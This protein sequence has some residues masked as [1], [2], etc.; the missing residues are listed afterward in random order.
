MNRLGVEAEELRGFI[1]AQRTLYEEAI[2]GY[3]RDRAV[4]EQEMKLKEEDFEEKIG[5]LRQRVLEREA[6]N[7]SITK[8]Y[9]DYKH[10]TEKKR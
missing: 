6:V 3:Q 7:Y 2:K 1:N 10:Q 9:F 4:R 8:E 5:E